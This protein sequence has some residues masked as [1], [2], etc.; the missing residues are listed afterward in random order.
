MALIFGRLTE[1]RFKFLSAVHSPSLIAFWPRKLSFEILH[2]NFMLKFF[3]SIIA[4]PDD[5]SVSY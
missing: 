5:G 2:L 1:Y 3:K 4:R